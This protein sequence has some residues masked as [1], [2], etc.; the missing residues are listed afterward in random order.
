MCCSLSLSSLLSDTSVAGSD[1]WSSS[2]ASE[3]EVGS[4]C[5]WF[6]PVQVGSIILLTPLTQ[7]SLKHREKCDLTYHCSGLSFSAF[8]LL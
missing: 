6:G 4:G 8:V 3:E 2:P 1:D 5:V 7:L